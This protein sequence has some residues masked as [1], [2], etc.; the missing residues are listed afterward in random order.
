VLEGETDQSLSLSQLAFG[1][2]ALPNLADNIK[3]GNSLIGTDYFADKL[4]SGSEELKRVNAFNWSDGF[5]DATNAGGFNC[6]IGNPPYIDSELMTKYYPE[7]RAYCAAHYKAARGNWDIFCVFIERAL[8]LCKENGLHGFIV[9]NKLTSAEY[10]AGIRTIISANRLISLR[11]YSKA[12]V[13][14]VAVYPIIYVIRKSPPARDA[15]VTY[16]RIGVNGVAERVV[17]GAK[18][19]PL[20]GTVGSGTAPWALSGD[21]GVLALVAKLA[22][23][24]PRLAAVATVCGAATVAEAYEMQPLIAEKP[25]PAKGDIRLVNSGTI[26]RYANLWGSEKCRYLGRTFLCPVVAAD[27]L[28]RVPATRARQSRLPKLIVAGMT[29]RLECIE[30]ITGGIMA[31]KSTSVIFPSSDLKYLLGIM[32]S[33]LI[34]FYYRTVYGGNALQGGYLRIGPPQLKEIPIRCLNVASPRDRAAHAKMSRLIDSM[35][36]LKSQQAAAKAVAIEAIIQ[37]QVDATDAEIDRLVY[38]LYGLTT[39]EIDIVEGSPPD[40][41]RAEKPLP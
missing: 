28:R 39:E 34:D 11:D 14:P 22:K 40:G 10:A 24:F 26:D 16:E 1:D 17:E 25:V 36:S 23:S 20:S 18:K 41:A 2:R 6:V 30:D 37:R 15:T 29:K 35:E 33:R 4:F 31:G 21:R 7:E 3:R 8:E 9:P 12:H 32:N 13:F 19:L 38:Q 27:K 5:P